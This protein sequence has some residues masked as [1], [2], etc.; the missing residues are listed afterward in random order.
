MSGTVEWNPTPKYQQLVRYAKELLKEEPRT[1]REVYYALVSRGHDYDYRQVKRA[2]KKGRRAG[3]IDPSRIRDPSRPVTVEP[4]KGYTS[5]KEFLAMLDGIEQEYTENYWNKQPEYVEVWLE[6]QALAS[7]FAP[8]CNEWNV[9]LECTRGDWSDAKVYETVQRL[10]QPLSQ[11]K[12][13]TILYFG[14]YNPSGYHA[15]VTIQETLTCYGMPITRPEDVIAVEHLEKQGIADFEE[16]PGVSKKE[17]FWYFDIEPYPSEATSAIQFD[18]IALNTEHID[19]FDLPEHPN[20]SSEDKDRTLRDRFM[21]LVSEGRDVNVELNALK[22]FHREW[23]NDL[24]ENS[25]REH[26]DEDAKREVEEHVK[27]RRST[28]REA[29]SVDESVLGDGGEDR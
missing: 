29:V 20:P 6:K 1:C 13:V 8:I 24:I 4:T 22:E 15:P 12:D 18:R 11:D 16:L 2:L 26:V 9:R 21:T 25:I 3:Y 14:D 19:R 17:D 23:F 5:P 10:R 27:E 28:L 7:L